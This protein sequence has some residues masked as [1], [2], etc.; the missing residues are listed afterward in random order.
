MGFFLNSNAYAPSSLCFITRRENVSI[1]NRST[2]KQCG[3]FWNDTIRD[4]KQKACDIGGLQAD[5]V[6]LVL[7]GKALTDDEQLWCTGVF[8]HEHIPVIQ[9]FKRLEVRLCKLYHMFPRKLTSTLYKLATSVNSDLVLKISL[10]PAA[11]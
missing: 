4:L 6:D 7:S 9:L 2:I 3:V 11:L 10:F 1:Q 8:D 5:S